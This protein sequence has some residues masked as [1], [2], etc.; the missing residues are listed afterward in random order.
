MRCAFFI[1]ERGQLL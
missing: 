1:A